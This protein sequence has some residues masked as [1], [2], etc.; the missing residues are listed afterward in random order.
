MQQQEQLQ[1]LQLQL[2]AAVQAEHLRWRST[3]E[4]LVAEVR[5]RW[6]GCQQVGPAGC[7][8]K[9]LGGTPDLRPHPE[10]LAVP[11]IA[12][13]IIRVTRKP[14][15]SRVFCAQDCLFVCRSAEVLCWSWSYPSLRR[16]RPLSSAGS[17][18]EPSRVGP[19]PDQLRC[20]TGAAGSAGGAGAAAGGQGPDADRSGHDAGEH[21][22]N[23]QLVMHCVPPSTACQHRVVWPGTLQAG[24]QLRCLNHAATSPPLQSPAQVN[25]ILRP[26][27]RC[28][29]PSTHHSS[30][31]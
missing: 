22:L 7:P 20:G 21:A 3:F 19:C 18:R 1:A 16:L 17:K 14:W 26:S 13:A 10:H 27:S 11:F 15:L 30:M 28:L 6:Q 29:L 12:P 23:P 31:Y 8:C 25:A 9:A 4:A 24:M 5:E 2:E